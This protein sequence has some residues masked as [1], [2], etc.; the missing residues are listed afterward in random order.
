MSGRVYNGCDICSVWIKHSSIVLSLVG[1][2]LQISRI[3]LEADH[4]SSG[5]DLEN[6]EPGRA[7]GTCRFPLTPGQTITYL[8]SFTTGVNS[9]TLAVQFSTWIYAIQ[10]NGWN[11]ATPTTSGPLSSST[12]SPPSITSTSHSCSG[13]SSGAKGGIG[14]SAAIGGIGIIA[15]IWAF[16]LLGRRPK[17]TRY[18][19]VQPV[20]AD[21]KHVH[22]MGAQQKPAELPSAR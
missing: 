12:S 2:H 7:V 5:Y 10:F 15:L 18:S 14:V 1:Y 19:T 20:Q 11:V 8:A 9:T 22:E 4:D 6:G 17:V 21:S 13:L 3:E 16:F